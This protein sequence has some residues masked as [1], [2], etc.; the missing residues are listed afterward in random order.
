MKLLIIYFITSDIHQIGHQLRRLAKMHARHNQLLS[1]PFTV[2]I[3][4]NTLDC[5]GLIC[6]YRN[7]YQQLSLICYLILIFMTTNYIA[8]LDRHSM[9][10]FQLILKLLREM[11]VVKSNANRK[12]ERSTVSRSSRIYLEEFEQ[13]YTQY[14]PLKL[15]GLCTIDSVFVLCC[16]LLVVETAVLIIQTSQ[17]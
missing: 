15:F 14:L 17:K 9:E 2:Y 8:Y 5:V 12:T 4:S 3:F 1:F 6:L 10:S 16:A 13:V 7:D 11:A